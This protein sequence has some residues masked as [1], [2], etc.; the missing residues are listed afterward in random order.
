MVAGSP[1][2]AGEFPEGLAVDPKGKF[3]YVPNLGS[4]NVSGFAID[5]TSGALTPLTASPFGAGSGPIGVV[6]DPRASSRM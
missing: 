1:F 4:G 2:F 6:V 3:A 5:A